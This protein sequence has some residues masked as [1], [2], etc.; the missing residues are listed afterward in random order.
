MADLGYWRFWLQTNMYE[1]IDMQKKGSFSFSY[2]DK[3]A[4]KDNFET[5]IEAQVKEILTNDFFQT[6]DEPGTLQSIV[7]GVIT[8]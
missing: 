7:E 5:A 3:L 4:Q 6:I 1:R 8:E 2:N